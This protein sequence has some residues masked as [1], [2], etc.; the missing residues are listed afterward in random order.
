MLHETAPKSLVPT[1]SVNINGIGLRR[2]HAH[3][4]SDLLALVDTCR[5]RIPLDLAVSVVTPEIE[6]PLI[7]PG[8][9]VLDHDRIANCS[10]S[11]FQ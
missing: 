11:R 7:C 9:L 1:N 5:G 4:E 8:L 2:I 3:I 10:V 6:L